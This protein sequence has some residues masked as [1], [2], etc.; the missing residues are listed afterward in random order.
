MLTQRVPKDNCRRNPFSRGLTSLVQPVKQDWRRHRHFYLF[1]S[2]YL[3]LTVVFMLFPLAFSFYI[4]F[5]EW[6]GIKAGSFVGF[7]NYQRLFHEALFWKSLFNTLYIW[8]IHM[9][10][11]LALALAFAVFLNQ[12][13]LK[14]RRVFRAALFLPAITSLVVV[15]LLFSMVLDQNF[16]LL[17]LLLGFAGIDPVPWLTSPQWSKVSLIMLLLWRWTGYVTVIML[18]GLQRIPGHLYEAARIDGANEWKAFFAITLPLMRPVILFA[19]VMGTIGSFAM[20]AEPFIL[21]GGG[22]NNSS[23]TTGLYLYREGFGYFHFGSA[24]AIAYFLFLIT[25]VLSLLQIRWLSDRG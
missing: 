14:M 3:L 25:L 5:F 7:D 18:A 12:A 13:W 22:P 19:F 11:E 16:G 8:A 1:V 4:S 9:P 6:S 17:N 15:A 10:I 21:T 24:S 2:P 20:F 23:L